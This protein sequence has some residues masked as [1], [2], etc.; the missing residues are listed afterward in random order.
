M[1]NKIIQISKEVYLHMGGLNFDEKDFQLAFGYELDKS[2][3]DYMREISL[4]VFYKD[5]PVKLGSPDFF[6]NKSKPPL[7]LELKLSSSIQNSHRQQLKMYLVSVKRKPKSVVANIKH[8]MIINF[9]KEDPTVAK[10][11]ESKSK[12]NHIEIEF[13]V[14][15]EYEELCLLNSHKGCI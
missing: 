11:L 10:H 13:Y 3:I 4:E 7:I 2:K 15:N 8:G 9:L 5:I 6:L 12:K 1:I 14:I